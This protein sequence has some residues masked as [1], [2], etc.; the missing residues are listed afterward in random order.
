MPKYCEEIGCNTIQAFQSCLLFP[1]KKNKKIRYLLV[2][3][4]L[5]PKP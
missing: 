4:I 5:H 2:L 1:L 3:L